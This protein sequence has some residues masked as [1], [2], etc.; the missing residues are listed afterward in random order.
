MRPGLDFIG[1]AMADD[2]LLKINSCATGIEDAVQTRV[3]L[4]EEGY[5]DEVASSFR[6]QI[7]C[8]SGKSILISP[9][10]HVDINDLSV[11]VRSG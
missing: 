10:Q 8:D 11:N 9:A 5:D 6:S 1:F 3:I 4:S 7:R 2:G